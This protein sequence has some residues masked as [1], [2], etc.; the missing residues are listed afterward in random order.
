[1]YRG[2]VSDRAVLERYSA[3]SVDSSVT[4]VG[5]LVR[6]I[7]A[8]SAEKATR[9]VTMGM[10]FSYKPTSHFENGEVIL[11]SCP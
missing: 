3:Q 9:V 1:M 11:C 8:M 2:S 4:R 10:V 7:A 5:V 6:V